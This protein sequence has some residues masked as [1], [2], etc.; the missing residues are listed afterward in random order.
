MR[1]AALWIGLV[2]FLGGG[3]LLFLSGSSGSDAKPM[4]PALYGANQGLW[5]IL[6]LIGLVVLVIGIILRLIKK[7]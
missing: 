3:I 2:L 1:K 7:K 4:V 5:T 6:A